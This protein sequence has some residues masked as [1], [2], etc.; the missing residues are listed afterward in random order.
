M[1][2]SSLTRYDAM[3]DRAAAQVIGQ[4]STSFSLATRMLDPGTRRDIRNLY[5]VVRIADEI[6]DGAT[7]QAH[8][9]PETA[10]DLYEEQVLHAPHHRFHTD[11]VLHAWANTYRRCHLN[12]DHVRA[13]FA[14][15]RRDTVQS[16]FSPE[17]LDEYIYGSAEVIG[18]LCL[19][20][21]LRGTRPAEAQMRTMEEGARALGSAFQKVN[22]L[23]DVGED[24]R[25]LG[26]AYFGQPL[27]EALKHTLTS[28]IDSELDVASRAI[29]L[30]P[31]RVRGG[32]VAAEALFRELNAQIRATPADVLAETRISVPNHRKL[33]LTARALA[34][35]TA[36][37]RNEANPK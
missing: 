20:I 9:C 2:D 31:R 4:Y 30:L 6:V 3:A 7:A 21:F 27:D 34:S 36:R 22:F 14:S 17:D 15:M 12:E 18:L 37:T 25:T 29:P 13:F 33:L 23:R 8:E 28:E 26:R 5:A 35:D 1:A 24:S 16:D 10:L 32:V 11:P 19:D